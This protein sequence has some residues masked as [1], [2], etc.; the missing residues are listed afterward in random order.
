M[1]TTLGSVFTISIGIILLKSFGL[2]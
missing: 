2:I 1:I